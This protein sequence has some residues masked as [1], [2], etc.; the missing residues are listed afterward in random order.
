[1]VIKDFNFKNENIK[2]D[3]QKEINSILNKLTTYNPKQNNQKLFTDIKHILSYIKQKGGIKT[4]PKFQKFD[5]LIKTIN[6]KLNKYPTD[7]FLQNI[8][9]EISSIPKKDS[10]FFQ[11]NKDNEPIK[12]L[13]KLVDLTENL[14]EANKD[15]KTIQLL[16]AHKDTLNKLLSNHIN[17]NEMAKKTY[18]N[19]DIKNNKELKDILSNIKNLIENIK[20]KIPANAKDTHKILSQISSIIKNN[21]KES[22]QIKVESFEQIIKKTIKKSQGLKISFYGEKHNIKHIGN[23]TN[24]LNKIV[25]LIQDNPKLKSFKQTIQNFTKSIEQI[26]LKDNIQNSGILY[27]SKIAH[28][29]DD[30][31]IS[32]NPIVKQDI[33]ATLLDLKNDI[34]IFKDSKATSL[35]DK[36]LTQIESFQTNSLIS[37]TFISYVPFLWEGLKEGSMQFDKLKKED[38]FSCKIELSLEKYG[39]LH[40][41][42]LLNQNSIS[43]G[44]EAKNTEFEKKIKSN[45][46]ELKKR[47]NAISLKSNIFFVNRK[48]DPF[49]N[50][51]YDNKID[52]GMDLKI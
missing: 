52:I 45:I 24:N 15:N 8:K 25:K 2:I 3:I 51:S 27:E 47:L 39:D 7:K 35:I 22:N 34:H 1:M 6:T 20:Q 11:I 14:I 10:N 12:N 9:N 41:L 36:T 13:F 44:I 18:L 46:K 16:K 32:N 19:L 49:L 38:N 33:K 26:N 29:I 40:M 37:S 31:N 43:I 4:L 28:N 50:N 42:L 23:I 21:T 30:K 48:N 5:N 17:K